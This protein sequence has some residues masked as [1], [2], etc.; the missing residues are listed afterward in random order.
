LSGLVVRDE[1]P[2]DYAHLGKKPLDL[3]NAIPSFIKNEGLEG[4]AEELL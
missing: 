1:S 3:G 2:S 4:V